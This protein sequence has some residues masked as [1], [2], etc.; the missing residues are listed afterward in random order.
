M[1]DDNDAFLK[2]MCQHHVSGQLKV[3]P[4]HVSER[5]LRL[6]G[7]PSKAVYDRFIDRYQRINERLGKKQ[8]VVPYFMSS[9][10]GSTILDAIE[11]A[12]Y[13]RDHN[14]RP[15]QVQDFIP[16]PGSLSTCMYYTGIHPL[17]GEKVY[18]PRSAQEKNAQRAMLQYFLP[19]NYES[20]Y[21]TLIQAGRTD[22]IGNSPKALIPPRRNPVGARKNL[23]RR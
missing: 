13:L 7:K 11:L 22:L 23:R 21:N 6:M 4:E 5:V 2:E 19:K 3:A 16:T 15:Q 1:L 14:I 18:I 8:F 12:E 20:V 17:T 10:P 9:H